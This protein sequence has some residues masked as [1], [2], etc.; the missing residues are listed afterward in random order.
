[1]RSAIA[2]L[3][4]FSVL[5]CGDSAT[6]PRC[7]GSTCSCSGGQTCAF[8]PSICGPSSCSIDCTDH[9][10]CTGSCADS[11]SVNCASGSRCTLSLG[12]SGSV[13]CTG[14]STCYI[15]CTG[16]CSVSCSSGSTCNL[17]CPND[18]SWTPIPQGGHC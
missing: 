3:G 11:C 14:N 15:T 6:P 16:S 1:M 18:A 10:V 12:Q 9:N 17:R 7:T 5:C 4:M 13:S 2:L 8:S